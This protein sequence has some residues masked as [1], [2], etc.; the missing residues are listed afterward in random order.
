VGTSGG[1]G[2]LRVD[3]ILT[4]L[5]TS[6][7]ADLPGHVAALDEAHR[8]LA[9]ILEAAPLAPETGSADADVPGSAS[10]AP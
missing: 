5:E 6:D 2:D 3:A 1:S 9:E 10:S 4:R 7:P 8:R